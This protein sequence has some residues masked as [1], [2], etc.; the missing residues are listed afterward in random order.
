MEREF[1]FL[2]LLQVDVVPSHM[3]YLGRKTGEDTHCAT[4]VWFED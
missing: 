3:T 1:P 2:E 4:Y